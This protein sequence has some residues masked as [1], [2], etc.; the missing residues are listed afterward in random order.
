M[1]KFKF[2]SIRNV[3]TMES[4]ELVLN[5]LNRNNIRD[6]LIGSGIALVGMAYIAVSAFKNGADE[7][8]KTQYDTF[9]SLGLILD[10][11]AGKD[12]A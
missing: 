10:D 12:E 6:F 8:D 3:D 5:A 1:F 11:D 9:D 7:Y 2:G 4:K